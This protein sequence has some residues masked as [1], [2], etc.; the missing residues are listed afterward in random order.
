MGFFNGLLFGLEW[1]LDMEYVTFCLGPVRL[2]IG[3]IADDFDDDYYDE[4]E[5]GVNKEQDK[6]E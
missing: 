4:L 5:K 1:D 3:K 6:N 2:F